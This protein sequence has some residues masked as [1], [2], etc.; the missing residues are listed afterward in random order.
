[1]I[2]KNDNVLKVLNFLDDVELKG[3][4]SLGRTKLR[5]VLL[6]LQEEIG[7]DQRN[8]IDE[9]NGWTDE[10]AGKYDT[11]N[12]EMTEAIVDLFMKKS[13]IKYSSPFSEDFKTAIEKYDKPLNSSNAEAYAVLYE[14]LIME[15]EEF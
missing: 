9:F 6:K 10:S 12:F 15:K 2:I 8:I 7:N 3:R 1:M 5:E 4:A 11:S 13:E 14:E